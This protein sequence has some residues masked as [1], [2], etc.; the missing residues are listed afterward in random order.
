MRTLKNL[1]KANRKLTVIWKNRERETKEFY[2]GIFK[3]I[4]LQNEEKKGTWKKLLP[5]G[6]IINTRPPICVNQ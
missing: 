6:K 1:R 2:E 3:L 4:E 5:C